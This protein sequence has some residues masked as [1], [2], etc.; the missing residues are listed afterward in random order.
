MLW[1]MVEIANA[2]HDKS[3]NYSEFFSPT[4]YGGYKTIREI[5]SERTLHC[6]L[7]KELKWKNFP[8]EIKALFSYIPEEDNKKQDKH[9]IIKTFFNIQK[10][11][12]YIIAAV[13]GFA[14]LCYYT[15]PFF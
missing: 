10:S 12:F 3:P 7:N 9:A 11:W 1:H 15:A 2:F 13:L 5:A 8:K 14:M 4:P 6:G